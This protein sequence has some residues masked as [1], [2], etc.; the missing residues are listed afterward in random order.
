MPLFCSIVTSLKVG[1]DKV[2]EL[3][4]HHNMTKEEALKLFLYAVISCHQNNQNENI[5]DHDEATISSA[6]PLPIP[7]HAH[8]PCQPDYQHQS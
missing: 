2:D 3:Q 1:E 4:Q 7:K 8:N 6:T 5:A